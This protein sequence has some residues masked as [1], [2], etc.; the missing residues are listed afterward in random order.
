MIYAA[1]EAVAGVLDEEILDQGPGIWTVAAAPAFRGGGLRFAV[2]GAGA[3][4]DALTGVISISTVAALADTVTVTA[5]NSGGVVSLAFAVTIEAEV[6]VAPPALEAADWSIPA[7]LELAS[8]R[9]AGVVE[10]AAAGPA[11]GAVA[12][13]WSDAAAP[14]GAG[15]PLTA[16]GGRRWRMDDP[17]GAGRNAVA[18][19]ASK[20]GIAVRYRLAADGLWSDW[21]EDRKGFSMPA[22]AAYWR[23]IERTPG[24]AISA[25]NNYGFGGQ[26]MRC[27]IACEDEPQF[28]IG[29][30]DMNGIRLSDTMGRTWYHPESDGLRAF[31]FNSV[32][33]DPRNHN[34]LLALGNMAWAGTR[35]DLRQ[36]CG[37]WRSTDFGKSWALVQPMDTAASGDEFNQSLFCYDPATRSLP[38]SQRRIYMMQRIRLQRQEATGQQLWVSNNGGATWA[39]LSPEM[40]AT[41]FGGSMYVLKH[42]PTDNTL[43]LGG[44]NGLWKSNTAKTSWTRPFNAGGL[45]NSDCTAIEIDPDDSNH[46]YAFILDGA[47]WRTATGGT[48]A[49]SWTSRYSAQPVKRGCV[50]W[51]SAEPVVYVQLNRSVSSGATLVRS[52]GAAGTNYQPPSSVTGGYGWAAGD[53]YHNKSL[54]KSTNRPGFEAIISPAAGVC[55]I[56][57]VGRIKRSENSG[58]AFVELVDRLQRDE[59]RCLHALGAG[60]AGRQHGLHRHPGA[61][62]Q[63]AHHDRRLPVDRGATGAFRHDG[64]RLPGH[65]RQ[66]ELL[67]RVAARG[68]SE[69]Q[70][71]HPHRARQ[72]RPAGSVPLD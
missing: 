58:D 54:S 34:Y 30:G 41:Q 59:Q 62:H 42:H 53:D 23:P 68:Q 19:G 29:G 31:G 66:I 24:A 10:A 20:S 11:A 49:A 2:T 9:H 55:V 5:T 26:Y 47:V 44:Q 1:P 36:F 46:M 64:I 70:R 6:I 33:I 28:I 3:S 27:L 37:I 14:A 50:D 8:G 4:V 38:A 65:G 32:F 35:T 60:A 13:E 51:R 16:L 57:A 18:A 22:P 48:A 25:P 61:G 69:P 40:A 15:L 71:R 39:K 45:P 72:R 56:N 17:S 12:L 63:P 67:R 43:L 21:S 7:T 52:T